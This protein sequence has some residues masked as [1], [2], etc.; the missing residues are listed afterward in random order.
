MPKIRIGKCL[1]TYTGADCGTP[2]IIAPALKKLNIT[3]G[4]RSAPRRLVSA[5]PIN[6]ELLLLEARMAMHA[7]V[8]DIIITIIIMII[9]MHVKVVDVFLVHVRDFLDVTPRLAIGLFT[10]DSPVPVV[11]AR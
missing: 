1:P 11:E 4:R 7:K 3:L 10:G 5:L 9:I 8:V 2:K 6:H